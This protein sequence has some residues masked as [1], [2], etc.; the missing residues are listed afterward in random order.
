MTDSAMVL[1]SEFPPGVDS[2]DYRDWFTGLS[3]TALTNVFTTVT[4]GVWL[5]AAVLIVFFLWAYRKPRLVPTRMQWM[6]E[7]A[8]GVVRNSISVDI[9]GK[10]VGVRFAPYL[11]TLFMFVLLT[12]F[13]AIVPVMQ[14]SPNSHIAFPAVLAIITWVIYVSVG[15][16][17]HGLGQFLKITVIPPG[18]PAFILPLLIPLEFLQNLVL[19]P[20]TLAL[21]LFANMFA[22]HL[23][24]LVFILG[25][26]AMLESGNIFIQGLSFV[27]MLMGIGLT[28]F[29]LIVIV[30]QAYVF[31]LLT[32]L[33]IQGSLAD[34]H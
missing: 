19:R 33:Y 4:F 22:G 27:S 13:L 21:R 1:A 32:T 12:N 17:K 5:A 14:I 29:E 31:T 3:D 16:R 30:L 15:I 9:L 20:L 11:T 24:L 34:E 23:I 25:G 6:A 7:S 28:L 2:F 8:Y 10:E 26:F 18:A